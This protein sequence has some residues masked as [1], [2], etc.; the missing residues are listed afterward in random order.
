MRIQFTTS[1]ASGT[2]SYIEGQTLTLPDPLPDPFRKWL[3]QGLI[4]A[5]KAPDYEVGLAPRA[6]ERAVARR[7]PGRRAR[8]PRQSHAPADEWP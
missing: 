8:R 6:I 4:R 5:L 1:V 3:R 2:A 7:Q